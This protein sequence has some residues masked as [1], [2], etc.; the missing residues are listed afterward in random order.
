MSS[1][2]KTEHL[3][4]SQWAASDGVCRGDFN[5]D[6]AIIDA[7]VGAIPL[8]KLREITTAV[9][10]ATVEF[11]LSDIDMSNYLEIWLD[12]R[13]NHPDP[14]YV[15]CRLNNLLGSVYQDSYVAS[16]AVG[17]W[18][19]SSMKP[20]TGMHRFMNSGGVFCSKRKFPAAASWPAARSRGGTG[21]ASPFSIPPAPSF[22]PPG[23]K[24]R[25]SG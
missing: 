1:T 12:I 11:D 20:G 21:R 2:S 9:A 4:L 17:S 8:V 19:N 22:S 14:Q 24:S 25:F 18:L 6:N 3:S 13:L 5:A 16:N 23:A 10:A 15:R 7:R